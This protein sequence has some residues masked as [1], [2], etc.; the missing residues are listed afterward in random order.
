MG[1]VCSIFLASALAHAQD[2]S[3]EIR[4]GASIPLEHGFKDFGESGSNVDLESETSAVISLGYQQRFAEALA[5]GAEFQYSTPADLKFDSSGANLKT[6][7]ST[8]RGFANLLASKTSNNFT[9]YVG[10]GLGVANVMLDK[11]DLVSPIGTL[12][13]EKNSVINFAFQF[14]GGLNFNLSDKTYTGF[15]FRFCD[16]GIAETST[17]ASIGSVSGT[18]SRGKTTNDVKFSEF[19]LGLGYIL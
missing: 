16:V 13:I 3:V 17:K 7:I 4:A 14:F 12:T 6:K 11:I 2:Q 8:M 18:H 9:P 1:I 5:W 19:T 10:I 15:A